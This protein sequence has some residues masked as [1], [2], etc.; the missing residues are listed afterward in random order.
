[1][2]SHL[3]SLLLLVLASGVLLV[4]ESVGFAQQYYGPAYGPPAPP[5][6]SG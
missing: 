6:P 2:R 5:P 1:M 4:G 3:R